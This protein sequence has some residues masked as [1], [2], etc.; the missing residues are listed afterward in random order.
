MPMDAE[1]TCLVCGKTATAEQVDVGIGL[2]Q[3]GPFH[4]VHCGWVEGGCPAEE[5][6]NC[7]SWEYC[8][9]KSMGVEKSE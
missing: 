4:C 9:G 2:M 8:Q 1:K 5:C 3:A 7:I 6:G